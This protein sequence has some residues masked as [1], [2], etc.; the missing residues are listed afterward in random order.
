MCSLAVICL[1]KWRNKR[2]TRPL[3]KPRSYAKERRELRRSEK[4]NAKQLDEAKTSWMK[5][6]IE[7]E[8]VVT[9]HPTTQHSFRVVFFPCFSSFIF[10]LHEAHYLIL[11]RFIFHIY[12]NAARLFFSSISYSKMHIKQFTFQP[13]IFVF[14][15]DKEYLYE[16]NRKYFS[17]ECCL[18]FSG[19]KF[20]GT[21]TMAWKLTQYTYGIGQ[22]SR[23]RQKIE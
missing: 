6:R 17:C 4:K 8:C 1:T 15:I 7:R 2:K 11:F 12:R 9:P 22:K 20:S 23:P 16:K 3:P 5:Q 13:T 19:W 10:Y 14:E 18:F 21:K